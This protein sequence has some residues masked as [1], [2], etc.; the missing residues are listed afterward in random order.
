[1]A[2]KKVEESIRSYLGSLGS[3]SKPVVDREAVKSLKQQIRNI[4]DPIEKLR[5]LA[6]LEDEQA[7]R[8]PDRSD[9]E[10][11][12]VEEAKAW[13][14]S[15]GIGVSAFQ[16]LKVPDDVLR[17][18][19]FTVPSGRSSSSGR[20]ASAGRAQRIPMEEVKATAA[21]LGDRWKL[22]DLAAALDRDPATIRNYVNKLIADGAV[23]DLGDDPQ[24]NGRGRAAKLYAST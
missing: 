2:P 1:M 20:T 23:E 12:F 8:L 4:D 15:E 16:S 24:H 14:E 21:S 3:G 22:G 6:A 19:G 9:Q 10:A 17:A 5:L 11:M 7:G 18:A 13:A